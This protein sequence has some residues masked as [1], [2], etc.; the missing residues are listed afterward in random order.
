M[1]KKGKAIGMKVV[2]YVPIKLNNERTPGKNIKKFNDGT[3]L[4]HF[5]FN[6]LSQVK[7]INEIYCFCSDLSIQS[8]ITGRVRFL[9]REKQLDTAETTC[10]DI[11]NSFLKKV[12][13]DIIVLAH[14]TC[15]FLRPDTIS[16]CIQMVQS[17]LYDS[18]FTASKVQDFLWR[19]GC[20][21]N[22]YPE[23]IARTQ[24]LPEI[25]KESV[26]CYV[27]TKD[28]FM[29]LQRRVGLKPFI[30]EVSKFE[31]IDIDYPEDFDIANAIYMNII[32]NSK[33]KH[34]I[35]GENISDDFAEENW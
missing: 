25:Y 2:A 1:V 31:E 24:D 35:D 33:L 34:T 12:D 6:T 19:D 20:P 10:Q 21:L 17:G 4:C 18:A 3:P 9:Q 7:E 23:K 28:M 32:K 29:L 13:A 26:G 16:K 22:F 5:I 30:C 15:P 27:F 11:V 8:F 14:A